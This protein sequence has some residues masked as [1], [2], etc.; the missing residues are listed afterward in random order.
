MINK[1]T[2]LNLMQSSLFVYLLYLASFQMDEKLYHDHIATIERLSRAVLQES[3]ATV[4]NHFSK[5]KN[6]FNLLSKR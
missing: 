5:H 2:G 3:D 6:P 4:S 1:A